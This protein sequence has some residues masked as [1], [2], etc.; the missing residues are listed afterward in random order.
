MFMFLEKPKLKKMVNILNIEPREFLERLK[1]N[2]NKQNIFLINSLLNYMQEDNIKD[3]INEIKENEKQDKDVHVLQNLLALQ[4]FSLPIINKFIESE[5]IEEYDFCVRV[6]KTMQITSTILEKLQEQ[7]RIIR[8]GA[9]LQANIKDSEDQ[10]QEVKNE[11]EK[12]ENYLLRKKEKIDSLTKIRIAKE[13]S[14]EVEKELFRK[15]NPPIVK[16]LSNIVIAPFCGSYNFMRSLLFNVS[17]LASNFFHKLYD[18]T[19]SFVS[20][21]CEHL[22][23]VMYGLSVLLIIALICLPFIFIGN[24][25][26]L[27]V[28]DILSLIITVFNSI[29][30]ASIE[31]YN[32][33]V[34]IISSIY[35]F[36]FSWNFILLLGLMFGLFC[37]VKYLKRKWC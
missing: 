36:V 6:D 37:L 18:V 24:F 5:F 33:F 34:Y 22:N 12:H 2:K 32:F 30:S 1:K 3:F 23:S 28:S 15:E 11:L 27:F 26:L 21:I 10:L 4:P 7:K 13:K 9:S 16:S 8:K 19:S 25:L 35:N 29:V 31:T 14:K 17:N 20:F